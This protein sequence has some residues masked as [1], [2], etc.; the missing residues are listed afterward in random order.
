MSLTITP[1]IY[2][3]RHQKGGIPFLNHMININYSG[4]WYLHNDPSMLFTINDQNIPEIEGTGNTNVIIKLTNIVNNYD[5][6][7]YHLKLRAFSENGEFEAE[8]I[9]VLAVTADENEY[10]FPTSMHFEAIRNVKEADEQTLYVAS[11]NIGVS[12]ALPSFLSLVS[13]EPLGGGH[14][15]KIKAADQATTPDKNYSGN[16]TVTIPGDDP[17]LVPVNY[18]INAG[19]DEDYDKELHFTRD[20]DELVFY[21]TTTE[22]SFLKLYINVRVFDDKASLHREFDLQFDLSFV[23]YK[24]RVNLGKEMEDYFFSK[25]L[26]QFTNKLK[27]NY[28]PLELRMTA[29]EIRYSDFTILN[30]D[31]IPLQKYLIGRNPLNI[32]RIDVPF[33]AE[34]R[35]SIER[36]I[37]PSAMVSLNIYKPPFD[38]IKNVRMEV[39]GVFRKEIVPDGQALGLRE[40]YFVTATVD[41]GNVK[42]GDVI[43]FQYPG[44]AVK[45]TFLVG[46]QEK[47]SLLVAYE[48]SYKTFELFEFRGAVQASPEYSHELTNLIRNEVLVTHKI[49]TR[50]RQTIRINTGFI[51]SD[52]SFI[53]NEIIQSKR[54]F[55]MSR[56]SNLMLTVPYSSE[57]IR[58]I[59]M[60]PVTADIINFDSENNRVEYSI[61]FEINKI[62]EDEIYTP[63][64]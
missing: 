48:T 19:F 38:D 25:D 9:I 2:F 40:G 23:D 54:A 15:F 16:I 28:T 21:Q 63:R 50:T 43:T 53:V 3:Y 30:Q 18:V 56:R 41:L 24:A 20:N 57:S 49:N 64:I 5:D 62:H 47:H 4:K 13:H 36:M 34:H 32:R 44:I 46:M 12:A 11:T 61:E 59:E 55:L 26:F 31:L 8:T 58:D 27:G 45:K 35:P 42:T 60:I 14:I 39:N 51:M 7:L 10:V 52:E 17:I 37:S 29:V 22:K 1:S 6:G 33:W